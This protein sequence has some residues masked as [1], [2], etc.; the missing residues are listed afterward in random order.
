MVFRYDP[1]SATRIHRPSYHTIE[2]FPG[3]SEGGIDLSRQP[4]FFPGGGNVL[5]RLKTLHRGAVRG[6]Y[7]KVCQIR[8]IDGPLS[9]RDFMPLYH[10]SPHESH[11]L[12][13]A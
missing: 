6:Y 13:E 1:N 4:I 11:T 10:H 3:V 12:G 8:H 2:P 7:G 9:L 5:Q